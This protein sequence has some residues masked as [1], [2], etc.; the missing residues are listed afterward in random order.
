M[1]ARSLPVAPYPPRLV[2]LQAGWTEVL[3]RPLDRTTGT[4]RAPT[5]HY[6]APTC[7][8]IVGGAARLAVYHRQYWF[9]LFTALQHEF[10]LTAALMGAW[11]FNG[12]A[13]DFLIASPPR[14]RGLAEVGDGLA[15]HV[16]ARAPAAPLAQAALVDEALR[17]AGRHEQA[18]ADS[19]ARHL[20]AGGALARLRPA[21]SL[22]V[23]RERWPLV[24]L[25]HQLGPVAP[26]TPVALPP[27]HPDGP[28]AWAV[29][30][31]THGQAARPLTPAQADLLELI[32]TWPLAQALA[33]FEDRH[34]HVPADQVQ[35]WLADSVQHG[36]WA[37]DDAIADGP[38]TPHHP[39]A[40]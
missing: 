6:P 34:P 17:R 39:I 28:R 14:A 19:A 33:S 22:T 13:S 16:V 40:P 37:D 12:L 15:A 32:G 20:R 9:R 10:R 31:T 27:P 3:R 26:T 8:E 5:E 18:G 30:A 36:Y 4:L 25:H 1:T 7:A 11:A 35:A 2:A 29:A 23:V 21:P 38:A 24:E